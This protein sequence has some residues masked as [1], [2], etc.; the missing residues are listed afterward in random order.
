MPV[1]SDEEIDSWVIEGGEPN[2]SSGPPS[3]NGKGLGLSY[4]AL[5]FSTDLNYLRSFTF[6]DPQNGI[7]SIKFICKD[8]TASNNL[9]FKAGGYTE[10]ISHLQKYITLSRSSKEKNL[11]LVIDPREDLLE[12]SVGMLDL[13]KD[14]VSVIH[15]IG[16]VENNF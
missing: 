2:K 12:K 11:V 10:L 13:N 14:L 15:L 16:N 5:V 1:Q 9:L 6:D 4:N 3:P 7:A 8:G